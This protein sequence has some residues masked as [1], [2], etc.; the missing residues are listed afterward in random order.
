MEVIA[1]QKILE[2]QAISAS[3]FALHLYTAASLGEGYHHPQ[4]TGAAGTGMVK[5]MRPLAVVFAVTSSRVGTVSF[6]E[7]IV[8][9]SGHLT[10]C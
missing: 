3:W 10:I 9:H 6:V 1:L 2:S 5:S 8:C 4:L 7:G